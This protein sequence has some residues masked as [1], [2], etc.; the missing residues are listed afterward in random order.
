MPTLTATPDLIVV[1]KA[2]GLSSGSTMIG[3]TKFGRSQELWERTGSSS[4]TQINVYLR[5]GHGNEADDA[6]FYPVMLK[7]GQVYEVGVFEADHGPTTTD[8]I[9]A[10]SELVFCVWKAPTGAKL[11]TDQNRDTGGTWHFHQI[12][13]GIPT[14]IVT[15]GVSQQTPTKDSNGIP[16]LMKT[17]GASTTP[18]QL[19]NDHR[20]EITPLI[21][22]HHYFFVVLVVDTLGNWDFVVEE[23]DTK[24]RTVSIE[25]TELVIYDDGDDL[26]TG[27]GEFWMDIYE[28]K[29]LLVSYHQPTMTIDDW[30][31]TGRPYA[32]SY[33]P[34]VIGPKAVTDGQEWIG[35]FSHAVEHDGWFEVDDKAAT[36]LGPRNLPIPTG[37]LKEVVTN[38]A[39]VVD[40]PPTSGSLHYSVKTEYSINYT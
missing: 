40:C 23:F 31:L 22:G 38:G 30:S 27:E 7:P 36:I 6:G 16:H 3:Y 21:P 1:D 39:F 33:G 20:H 37:R 4:W 17:E 11:I 32:I 5:T 29:K 24:L 12:H 35:I 9:K 28:A 26:N 19:A 2:L 13:T 15:M 34:S 10:I 8:P 14:S 25:F 18:V